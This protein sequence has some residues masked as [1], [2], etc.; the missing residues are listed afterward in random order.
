VLDALQGITGA[1][2]TLTNSFVAQQL[3]TQTDTLA[4]G[5]QATTDQIA[6]LRRE[7]QQMIRGLAA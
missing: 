3:Q 4:A 6:A 2:D 7:M 5:Q 1:T